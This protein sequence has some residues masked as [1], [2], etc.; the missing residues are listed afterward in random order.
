MVLEDEDQ[1]GQLV[2]EVQVVQ[3]DEDQGDLVDLVDLVDLEGLEDLVDR[4][5]RVD[6]VVLVVTVAAVDS[7]EA[8]VVPEVAD[9]VAA[10][11]SEV[12]A[13]V[14]TADVSISSFLKEDTLNS[15]PK[16]EINFL[17]IV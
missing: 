2:L 11:D 5:D 14:H 3:E 7:E 10:V 13:E 8:V 1:V 6:R 12:A 4:V 16:R 17:C 15:C 9:L